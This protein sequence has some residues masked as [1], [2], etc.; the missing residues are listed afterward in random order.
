MVLSPSSTVNGRWPALHVLHVTP[1]F[2]PTW[3]YGGIP[4]IVY[5]LGR[6]L[7]RAGIQVSV[8]TTDALDA[9]ERNG[10]PPRRTLE[11]MEV[12]TSENL[13]NS[14][15]Y[16]QQLFLPRGAGAALSSIGHVDV[17]H[18]HGHRHLLNTWALRWAR[19]RGIPVVFTPNGTLP[20][21][22]R[23]VSFKALWDLAVA[24]EV[25]REAARSIAVAPAE[26]GHMRTAGIA[27][28]RIVRI[29]N[30]LMLEEFESLPPRGAFREQWG[31][32]GPIVAYLGRISPRKGV[33][34]LASAAGNPRLKGATVVVAGNDMGGL[35]TA[36]RA[37]GEGVVFTGL[38]EGADRLSLLVD[39]DVLVYASSDEIFGL[40]P[41]EGLMCGTPAVVGGDCGCGEL[42][43]EAGAGLLVR[44]SDVEGLVRR[45]QTLL[46]DAEAR[47][48]M[49]RRGR[50]YVT[51]K[52][53]FDTLA[54]RHVSLYKEVVAEAAR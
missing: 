3:A 23:K 35:A 47:E 5:G 27:A 38:L 53:S 32:E 10:V 26:V 29:P 28:D 12:F 18:L 14:L 44:H 21:L 13:S 24:A 51:E 16:H 45:I 2:P 54:T 31:I 49:V 7:V 17:V 52:L 1:Y 15:A 19:Q 4:R 48:A 39:A 8:W 33:E 36:R 34:H 22:E 42:I 20:R 46:E 11:G 40:V 9:H 41:F 43:Q 6:A 30:G 50:R 25:P 37:A